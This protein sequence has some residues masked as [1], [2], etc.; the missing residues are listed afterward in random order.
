MLG[1][2]LSADLAL[3][4]LPVLPGAME[5]AGRGVLPGGTVGTYEAGRAEVVRPESEEAR[6]WLL[7]DAQTSGGLLMAVPPSRPEPLLAALQS[8][9]EQGAHIGTVRARR[10]SRW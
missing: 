2:D 7:F 1:D 9:G 3:E 10:D 8:R 6:R 5:L 4:R